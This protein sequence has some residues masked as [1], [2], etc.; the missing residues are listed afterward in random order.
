MS[1]PVVNVIVRRETVR[2]TVTQSVLHLA[3][4]NLYELA[5]EA[6]FTGT[7][8]DFIDRTSWPIG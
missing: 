2:V 8:Q 5:Q 4:K 6:G 3:H 7:L 1:D